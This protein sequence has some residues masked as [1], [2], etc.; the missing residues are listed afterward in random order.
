LN[1]G[2]LDLLRSVD[3]VASRFPDVEYVIAGARHNS[4]N[5]QTL[6]RM[7]GT[8][9]KRDKVR[10]LGHVAWKELGE[11][12]RRASVF[13][14]A[15]HYETFGISV[16]EAM[17]FG[18]PVIA[19]NVGGLPEVVEDGV[20]GILVPPRDVEA[21]SEAVLRLLSDQDLRDRLGRA[22][23]ERVLNRFQ[24]EQIVEQTLDVYA[25]VRRQDVLA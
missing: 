23:R 9:G 25:R 21:L 4:I 17:A 13:V 19:T 12:Y 6:A 15:S 14:M 20:T 22:G 2:T 18:L 3:R 8:N 5:D 1:K 11:W 7:L 10:L 16:I 24:P